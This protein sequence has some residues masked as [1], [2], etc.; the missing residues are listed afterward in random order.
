MKEK[1]FFVFVLFLIFLSTGFTSQLLAAAEP[2]GLEFGIGI[3]KD[4]F[5]LGE[6]IWL[7][8]YLKNI[9]KQP[10]PVKPLSIAGGWLE[11]IVINSSNDTLIPYAKE[12]INFVGGGPTYTLESGETLY[13]CRDLLEATGLGEREEKWMSWR[14]YLKPDA[15]KIKARYQG[16]VQ[17]NE[18]AFAVLNP[19]GTEKIARR[20]WKEGHAEQL[21]TRGKS[22]SSISKWT[23]L[24]DKYP[25]SVYAPS[26]L[27]E[28]LYCDSHNST[29]HAQNL[30]ATHPNSGYSG[31]AI[32]IL[33]QN[34]SEEQQKEMYEQIGRQYAGTRAD[35]LAKNIREGIIA[36]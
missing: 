7:D 16:Y 19:T 18:L 20:M 31:Y 11:L 30:L 32:G 22:G 6:P 1:Q 23:E 29:K 34:K 14:S 36:Y 21:K 3:E 15:Y 17:S 10:I 24:I 25:N 13:I 9:G 33:L 5:L 28:L 8:M 2:D 35:K 12:V 26:A 4:T 27:R